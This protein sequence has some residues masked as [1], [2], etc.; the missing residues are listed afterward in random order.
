MIFLSFLAAFVVYLIIC[1]IVIAFASGWAKKKGRSPWRW[2]IGAAFVMYNLVFWD[3]LPT[4]AV[5]KY[6]CATKAGFWVYK[7]PEQWKAE[8][9]GV[10]ETLTWRERSQK[11]SAPVATSGYWLNERIVYIEK[12]AKRYVLPVG[13]TE[14]LIIDKQN[15]NILV[16][17][18][19]VGAGY[20]GGKG[21]IKFWA[22]WP[23][24]YPKEAIFNK[25]RNEFKMLGMKIE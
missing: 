2:G 12:R 24:Y 8:N 7:T 15:N 5:Y 11:Y 13:I 21:F 18:I 25:Y 3:Y 1:L 22:N 19:G 6:H 9:P 14:Y 16:R 17:L 4:M 10:A 23:S 20:G